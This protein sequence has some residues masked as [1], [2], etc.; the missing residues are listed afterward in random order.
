[1]PPPAVRLAL[2]GWLA[3]LGAGAGVLASGLPRIAGA[4]AMEL[5]VVGDSVSPR[6]TGPEEILARLV[7]LHL[8]DVPLEAALRVL[9]HQ[10]ELRLSY[11]SDI[12]PLMRRVSYWRDRVSAG[13]AIR[14]LLLKG[15]QID[16]GGANHRSR[17]GHLR[18]ASAA[19]LASSSAWSTGFTR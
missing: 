7:S 5:A 13:E 4:Q 15:L 18:H 11:S 19:I 16:A 2:Q 12:V 8:N 10:A 17:G 1:M 3:L 14:E 9:A 6:R